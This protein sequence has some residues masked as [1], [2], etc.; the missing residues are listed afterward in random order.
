VRR[1]IYT[2]AALG[3]GAALFWLVIS[4][5]R[6]GDV[7]IVGAY[8]LDGS[9]IIC[10]SA[11]VGEA[12]SA[13]TAASLP[14]IQLLTQSTDDGPICYIRWGVMSARFEKCVASEQEFSR[15]SGE[16]RVHMDLRGLRTRVS[17][18]GRGY[19]VE[20]EYPP[21]AGWTL[22]FGLNNPNEFL[23]HLGNSISGD[24]QHGLRFSPRA[25][26]K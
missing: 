5:A 15:L 23:E 12:Q 2:S 25:G 24:L 6:G 17:K 3:I 10:K 8:R 11:S 4:A 22:C 7:F 13:I 26:Q 9:L 14:L 19:I 20:Q 21:P 1:V 16:P 18:L